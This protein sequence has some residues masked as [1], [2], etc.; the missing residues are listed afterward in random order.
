MINTF[1]FQDRAEVE[2]DGKKIFV[3]VPANIMLSQIG[4][5]VPIIITHPK[6][7]IEQLTKE[8]KIVPQVE[9]TLF[10]YIVK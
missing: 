8:G 10:K 7:V 4:A 6:S 1:G 5:M 2:K 3:P 9:V